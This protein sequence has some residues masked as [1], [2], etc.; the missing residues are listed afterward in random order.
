[1][2][3]F[4][5]LTILLALSCCSEK[6][7]DQK[8]TEAEP[9]QIA[10]LPE[11]VQTF[12]QTQSG[13]RLP[14]VDDTQWKEEFLRGEFHPFAEADTNRDGIPDV[15]ATIQLDGKFNVLVWHGVGKTFAE[16]VWLVRGDPRPISGVIVDDKGTITPVHCYYC[17]FNTEY[18]W[19]GRAYA[20][21]VF[22]TN[23][24]ACIAPSASIY[25]LPD[26]NSQVMLR[27]PDDG[28]E[29]KVLEAPQWVR[30][31]LWYRVH[32]VDNPQLSGFTEGKNLAVFDGPCK[33][34]G[35]R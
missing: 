3:R 18:R 14:T 33:I 16:P 19:N 10:A 31:Q 12:L 21:G 2:K 32:L 28:D 13:S 4:F 35:R 6:P 25:A 8:Q 27:A 26:L 9:R 15:V 1:M 23:E 5:I 30:N 29:A 11:P 24:T 20:Q 34:D 22:L 7:Q 17:D